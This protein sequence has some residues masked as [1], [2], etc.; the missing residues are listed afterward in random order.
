MRYLEYMG[1]FRYALSGEFAFIRSLA[2]GI[3]ISPT[4]GLEVSTLS[5]VFNNTSEKR[6]C[7]TE[8]LDTYEHK[9]QALDKGSTETGIVKMAND[10]AQTIFRVMSQNGIVLSSEAFKAVRAS[11]FQESRQAILQYNALSLMND[12]K[13]N[14]QKEITAVEGFVLAIE[15]AAVEF[16]KDPLGVPNLSSWV[17]VRGMLPGIS[18]EIVKIVMSDNKEV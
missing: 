1:S 10:I 5:E 8:I 14:R 13:Y 7:Q 17:S 18:E 3:R 16:S 2:R 9:H 15:K 11:C 12:L 4:W 6:I